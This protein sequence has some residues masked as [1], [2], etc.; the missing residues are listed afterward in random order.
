MKLF[1]L[2]LLAAG[3][4]L[5]QFTK[6]VTQG[7][8]LQAQQ[9]FEIYD[10]MPMYEDFS[11]NTFETYA[12]TA[13]FP[14]TTF[15]LSTTGT[16]PSPYSAVA[17]VVAPFYN[18]FSGGQAGFS[19]LF[20]TEAPHP[21]LTT[22]QPAAPPHPQMIFLDGH[23]A[24]LIALDMTTLNPVSQVVVPSVVGPFGLR[25]NSTGPVNEVW[26]LNSGN[27]IAAGAEVSVVNLSTQT[28]VTNIPTPSIPASTFAVPVGIVFTTDGAT[29]FEVFKYDSPDSSGNNGAMVVFNA[30]ARTVTSTMPLKFVPSA[31]LMSPDG[32]TVYILS[33]TG[34]ITYYDVLSGTAGLTAQSVQPGSDFGYPGISAAVA[35]HPDGTRLFW[36]VGVYLVVFDL[37]TRQIVNDFSSGLPTTINRTFSLSPDGSMAYFTDTEGDVAVL[38]TYYGTVLAAFNALGVAASIYGG[39]PVAP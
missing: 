14:T 2:Y 33:G 28:V 4:L 5:A 24:G 19:P 7:N 37:T 18:Y 1:C 13:G 11:T 22:V 3:S 20:K 36:N 6:A 32:L 34:T 31:L 25:P 35:I 12:P 10:G 23:Q 29:A 30:V 21:E 17:P 15:T 38:D 27:E 8:V 9:W 16:F 26:V 39:P